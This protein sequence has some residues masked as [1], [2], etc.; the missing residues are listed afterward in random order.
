M[1]LPNSNS[2]LVLAADL[3]VPPTHDYEMFLSLSSVLRSSKSY[4]SSYKSAQLAESM[5]YHVQSLEGDSVRFDVPYIPYTQFQRSLGYQY[6]LNYTDYMLLVRAL[7]YMSK[8]NDS[9]Y[10]ASFGAD[11]QRIKEKICIEYQG[12]IK[13]ELPIL[14]LA[15][16]SSSVG[17]CS[18][19]HY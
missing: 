18:L 7:C 9:Y 6:G 17:P 3:N 14:S 16:S 2:Y 1:K 19:Y 13:A 11:I 8:L 12:N 10:Y 5:Q 15:A 4:T